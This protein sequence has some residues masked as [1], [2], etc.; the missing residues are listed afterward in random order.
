MESTRR[1]KKGTRIT[2][3][4][5]WGPA[6]I[7]MIII[8]AFSTRHSVTVSPEY[9]WNFLF[10][11]LLHLIEYAV[12]FTLTSRAIFLSE[13]ESDNAFVYRKAFVITILYAISDEIHQLFVP[14]RQGAPRDVIIDAAGAGIVWYCLFTLL[15]K[16][17]IKLRNLAR[18][19][20]I[21]S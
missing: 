16:A 20:G 10:F 15:P 5:P 6:I 19:L 18:N 17:P 2:R 9:I 4:Y 21:P 11:K 14:S 8:F 12:L 13:T 3:V 7:W 1:P